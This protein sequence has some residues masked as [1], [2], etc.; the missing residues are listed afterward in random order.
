MTIRNNK[1]SSVDSLSYCLTVQYK[2]VNMHMVELFIHLFHLTRILSHSAVAN[3]NRNIVF[4]LQTNQVFEAKILIPKIFLLPIFAADQCENC[5]WELLQT[6]LLTT[7]CS[8]SLPLRVNKPLIFD[9][10]FN[11]QSINTHK[12]VP[13]PWWWRTRKFVRSAGD[14]PRSHNRRILLPQ[15]PQNPP[16]AGDGPQSG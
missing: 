1:V 9:I 5:Q 6:N 2:I 16:A 15:T 4:D 3:M 13:C 10:S 12:H 11:L 8:H 7:F 14:H